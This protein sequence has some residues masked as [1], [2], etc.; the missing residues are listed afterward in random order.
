MLD[1]AFASRTGVGGVQALAIAQSLL[2]V[3]QNLIGGAVATVFFPVFGALWTANQRNSAFES[4]GK[5]L[6]LAVY[7]LIPVVAVFA[8]VGDV[9]VRIVYQHGKFD[10]GMTL[11][12][13]HSAAAF[14]I[15]QVAYAGMLLLRQFLLV[16]DLPWAVF[17]SAAVFLAVKWI[18]NLLLV[19][20]FG[21]AGVA[22]SASLASASAC[23]FLAFRVARLAKAGR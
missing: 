19:D 17:V 23:A 1:N 22:L 12:V 10:Q 5:A 21:V 6:R 11:L 3:P 14:A 16:A 8:T 9:I 7:A 2:T 15:G 4:L 18:G 20:H 13:S